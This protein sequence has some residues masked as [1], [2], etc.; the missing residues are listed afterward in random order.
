MGTQEWSKRLI[1]RSGSAPTASAVPR[2]AA[3]SATQVKKNLVPSP[4]PSTAGAAM[5][6]PTPPGVND[7]A[8]V[9]DPVVGDVALMLR[10]TVSRV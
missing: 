2:V 1:T 7:P 3:T 5:A 6:M 9:G 10:A 4:I 8:V